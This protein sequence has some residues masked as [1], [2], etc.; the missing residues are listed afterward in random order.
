VWWAQRPAL[1]GYGEQKNPYPHGG[2]ITNPPACMESYKLPFMV[3]NT[4]T[5]SV[6]IIVSNVGGTGRGLI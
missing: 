3:S 6:Y 4:R 1:D 2:R 5:I